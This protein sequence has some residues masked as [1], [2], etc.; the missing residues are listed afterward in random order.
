MAI[1]TGTKHSLHSHHYN[2]DQVKAP[3]KNYLGASDA[4]CV[5]AILTCSVF[6]LYKGG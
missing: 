3:F 2:I 4:I 5:K 1:M 6:L